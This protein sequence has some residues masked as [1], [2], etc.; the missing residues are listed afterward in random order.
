SHSLQ[1][2]EVVMCGK[3]THGRD[4]DTRL[5]ELPGVCLPLVAEDI[6]LVDDNERRGQAF[7]LL[8]RRQQRSGRGLPAILLVGHRRPRTTPW[9]HVSS[10]IYR[11]AKTLL[12]FG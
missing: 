8:G 9:P 5:H 7:Q 12:S 10:V 3:E 4:I 2:D 11:A 6:V 1:H